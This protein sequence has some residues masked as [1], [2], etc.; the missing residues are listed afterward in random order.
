MGT[1][2][3][4]INRFLRRYG[5]DEF[6]YSAELL[7]MLRYRECDAAVGDTVPC[8]HLRRMYTARLDALEETERTSSSLYRDLCQLMASLAATPD[9]PVRSWIFH[10]SNHVAYEVFEKITGPET[11]EIAGCIKGTW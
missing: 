9:L 10:V 11:G 2:A 5:N 3:E 1:R 7:Q 8:R 4:T 6:P